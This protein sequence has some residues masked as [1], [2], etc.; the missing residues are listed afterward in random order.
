MLAGG[1]IL[2]P[3]LALLFRLT[4]AGQLVD[5]DSEEIP[6]GVPEQASPRIATPL[7]ARIAVACLIAGFGLLT[8]ADA[9]WTHAIGVVC[10]LS[11][12]ATA[13]LALAGSEVAL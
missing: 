8:V 4:L 7:L 11:F 12:V 9:K 6:G 2:F 3:S 13:F 5:T 10:L 1:A